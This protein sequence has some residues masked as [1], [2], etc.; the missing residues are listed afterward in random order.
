[1]DVIDAV[2]EWKMSPRC[3]VSLDV[4]RCSPLSGVGA[5]VSA[6]GLH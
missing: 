6:G 5:G 1:M 3:V 2:C 4:F